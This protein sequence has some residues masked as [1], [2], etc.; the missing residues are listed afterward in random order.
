MASVDFELLST[1]SAFFYVLISAAVAALIL[2]D[3]TFVIYAV[4]V[5][6]I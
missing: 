1:A 2:T 4:V 6:A 5:V 3:V